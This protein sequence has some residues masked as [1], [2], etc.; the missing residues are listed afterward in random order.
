MSDPIAARTVAAPMGDGTNVVVEATFDL[1][2][3]CAV[4]D[5]ARISELRD[6]DVVG[7]AAHLGTARP[8][9]RVVAAL[10]DWPSGAAPSGRNAASSRSRTRAVAAHRSGVSS[11]STGTLPS[12]WQP[13]SVLLSTGAVVDV[14]AFSSRRR[15]PPG[16]QA[17]IGV[18]SSELTPDEL[19]RA[20]LMPTV[21]DAAAAR[22]G[23]AATDGAVVGTTVG[24]TV[25]AVCSFAVMFDLDRR[26]V[27]TGIGCANAR[28][29]AARAAERFLTGTLDWD[30]LDLPVGA[31]HRFGE[32]VAEAAG[33]AG[34]T[35]GSDEYRRHALSLLATRALRR[36]RAAGNADR[37]Q[38]MT[39]A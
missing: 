14:A 35:Y 10:A 6:W 11:G 21:A 15:M 27:S 26:S 16:S 29:L 30:N 37:Y 32:L 4:P 24:G 3:R 25:S 5:F 8:Y 20:V 23:V 34:D 22:A 38:Q 7:G 17:F 36:I 33:P 9:S 1:R 13:R 18:E 28:P 39:A 31:A 2:L 12:E 19:I